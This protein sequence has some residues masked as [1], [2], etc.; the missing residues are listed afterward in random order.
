MATPGNGW[1]QGYM[2]YTEGVG[3]LDNPNVYGCRDYWWWESG[4][5]AARESGDFEN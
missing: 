5:D 3:L 4:W 2:D 1:E